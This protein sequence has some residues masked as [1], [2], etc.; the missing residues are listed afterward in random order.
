[1]ILLKVLVRDNFCLQRETGLQG[2][3]NT[4]SR[5]RSWRQEAGMAEAKRINYSGGI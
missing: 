5:K 4:L 3:S 1:M 2:P